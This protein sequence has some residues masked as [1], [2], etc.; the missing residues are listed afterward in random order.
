MW[1]KGFLQDVTRFQ[2]PGDVQ[3]WK[4]RMEKMGSLK[5]AAWSISTSTPQTAVLSHLLL[6]TF[7]DFVSNLARTNSRCLTFLESRIRTLSYFLGF[8]VILMD[9]INHELSKQN[10][11]NGCA[12]GGLEDVWKELYGS[13]SL[14]ILTPEAKARC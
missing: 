13:S 10:K 6:G 14:P 9:A 11:Q 2:A 5:S 1:P 3:G 7:L 12:G 8:G 4:G